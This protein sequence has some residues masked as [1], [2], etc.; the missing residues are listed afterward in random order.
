MCST[1]ESRCLQHTPIQI[2]F[3]EGGR[4]GSKETNLSSNK[5]R[6]TNK[7]EGCS[8][9]C[10]FPRRVKTTRVGLC[11]SNPSIPHPSAH[12]FISLHHWNSK[13]VPVSVPQPV[14]SLCTCC[15]FCCCCR[16]RLASAAR[17]YA[18]GASKRRGRPSFLLQRTRQ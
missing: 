11:L 15:L 14:H 6:K 2:Y 4:R 3:V 16:H 1:C 5:K 13:R 8:D 12:L 9:G 17:R 10:L 7:A 18:N